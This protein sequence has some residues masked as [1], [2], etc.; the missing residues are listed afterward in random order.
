MPAILTNLLIKCE[1]TTWGSKLPEFYRV[2]V[3]QT[4]IYMCP[5][6]PVTFLQFIIVGATDKTANGQFSK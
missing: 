6:N 3:L 5:G 4:N 1:P 2:F